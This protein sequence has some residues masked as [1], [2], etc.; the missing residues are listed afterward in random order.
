MIRL[1]S[2]GTP[3]TPLAV[4]RPPIVTTF[5]IIIAVISTIIT[6]II[7]YCVVMGCIM[8]CVVIYSSPPLPCAKLF[9]GV[10]LYVNR[11]VQWWSECVVM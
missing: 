6:I 9:A 4:L 3:G 8:C 10:V 2:F 11:E 1:L 7:G 5:I